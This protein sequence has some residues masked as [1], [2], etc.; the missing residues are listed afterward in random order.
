MFRLFRLSSPLNPY[1][2]SPTIP[3]GGISDQP[4]YTSSEPTGEPN[5]VAAMAANLMLPLM[6][7]IILVFLNQE[8]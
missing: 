6:I 4:G 3:G 7:S 1:P 8:K 5:S 2:T